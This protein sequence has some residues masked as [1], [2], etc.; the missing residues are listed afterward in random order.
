VVARVGEAG[1]GK[2]RLVHE[3]LHA[4]WTHGWRVPESTSVSYGKATTYFPVIDL[5]ERYCH[6][7]DSDDTRTIC[8]KVTGQI[9]TLDE[10]LQDTLP[11]LLALLAAVP[12]DS[13]FLQLDPP[14]PPPAHPRRAQAR[15]A[16]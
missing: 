14:Q 15:A 11:A 16:A 10:T 7:D 3:V 9:V 4:H 1:V 12:D 8:A 6:V 2:S 13:A 5:L